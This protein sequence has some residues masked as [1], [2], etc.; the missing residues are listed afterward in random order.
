MA[1][2]HTKPPS[3]RHLLN[4]ESV[5]WLRD[6]AIVV[7]TARGDV[8]LDDA[9]I[10]ALKSG[11][12]AAAGLDVFENEPDLNPEYRTLKNTFLLPHRGGATMQ[13]R[14]RLGQ[15]CVDNLTAFFAGEPV[16]GKVN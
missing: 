8:V 5:Q 2:S 4:H 13:T 10:G 3:T 11:K 16:P 12:V 6:G 1:T 7:N 9:L 15:A 14:I